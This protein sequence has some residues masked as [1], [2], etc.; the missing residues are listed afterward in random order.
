MYGTGKE[1]KNGLAWGT[2]L[3]GI[4]DQ[5]INVYDTSDLYTPADELLTEPKFDNSGA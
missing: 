3:I 1:Y 4:E 5:Y 2:K